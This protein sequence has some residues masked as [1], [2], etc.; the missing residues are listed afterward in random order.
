MDS[1][2]SFFIIVC[3]MGVT[4][5]Y[6]TKFKDYEDRY[7]LSEREFYHLNKH[8]DK[9]S[10]E[11]AN[12]KVRIK[13]LQK[14]KNDVSKT[15][16]IL[17]NELVHINNH[18][19]KNS[20][21]NR[22]YQNE[23]ISLLTPDILTNLIENMNQDFSIFNNEYINNPNNSTSNTN[24]NE[25]KNNTDEDVKTDENK[26]DENNTVVVTEN[27]ATVTENNSTIP[28]NNTAITE[29]NTVVTEN[30]ILRSMSFP[31]LPSVYQRLMLPRI[32]EPVAPTIDAIII[33]KS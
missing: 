18:V 1:N 3:L 19:E 17:D 31:N 33:N 20:Q 27:N 26:I 11:N 12:Y 24:E 8:I 10:Y 32:N 6:Y 13:D 30:N 5:Y 28:E 29:N 23:Q 16:K 9:L 15:F 4:F 21:M 7:R 25:E 2:F 14:Y 22:Q